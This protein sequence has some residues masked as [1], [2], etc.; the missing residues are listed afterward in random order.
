MKIG[1]HPTFHELIPSSLTLAGKFGSA[2]TA[3]FLYP[4]DSQSGD[5]TG[6][7]TIRCTKGVYWAQQGDHPCNFVGR[8]ADGNIHPSKFVLPNGVEVSNTSAILRGYKAGYNIIQT[9]GGP[10]TGGFRGGNG[11]R[12]GNSGIGGGG[13]GGGGGG[14]GYGDGSFTIVH[15]T[16]GGSTSDAKVVIRLYDRL[17]M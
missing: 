10:Q 3:P 14:S 4:G 6:G 2:Y 15:T 13:N 7:Q 1:V 16:Q 11:A 9:A 17:T 8:Q 12:G 5:N